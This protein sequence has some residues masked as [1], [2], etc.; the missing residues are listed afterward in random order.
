MS[1]ILGLEHL[2]LSPSGP[3]LTMTLAPGQSLGVVGP[4]AA[5]KSR[6]LRILAGEERPAQGAA[7][8]HGRVAVASAD[9]LSRRAKVQSL[10]RRSGTGAQDATDLLSALG[11]WDARGLSIGELTPTQLA[12]CELIEPLVSGAA[13]LIIDGQLDLLDP[14]ALRG[15]IG[16][17]RDRLGAGAAV[18]VATHRPDVIESLDAVVVLRDQQVRFAGT[19]ADLKRQGPPHE[20]RI[21]TDDQAAVRAL[22]APFTVS[23]RATDDGLRMEAREGQELAARLLLEGYGD[24]NFVIVRPPTLEEAILSLS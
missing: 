24:V 15:A 1:E 5:G 8:A 10:A 14:W 13:L 4:A 23:V 20:L 11:L 6:L 17:L 9:G 2:S 19:V 7:H 3:T 21:A 18:V 12:A 16:V 22:V